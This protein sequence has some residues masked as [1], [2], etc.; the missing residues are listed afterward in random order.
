MMKPLVETEKMSFVPFCNF[1]FLRTLLG[2]VTL[3]LLVNVALDMSQR[4]TGLFTARK[5]KLLEADGGCQ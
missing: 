1:A 5:T 4:L 2:M 3:P